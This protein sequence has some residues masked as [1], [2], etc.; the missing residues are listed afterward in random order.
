MTQATM[1]RLVGLIFML[2]VIV[3]ALGSWIFLDVNPEIWPLAVMGMLA[4]N[5]ADILDIKGDE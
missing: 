1:W 3:I 5:R 2:T 4:L